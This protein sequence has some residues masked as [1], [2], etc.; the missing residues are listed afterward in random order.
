[1]TTKYPL[2]VRLDEALRKAARLLE[3][4]ADTE[5]RQIVWRDNNWLRRDLIRVQTQIARV[6]S[7]GGETIEQLRREAALLA[8]DLTQAIDDLDLAL[9]DGN[10]A[11]T[12]AWEELER[13][14]AVFT[15]RAARIRDGEDP[16]GDD[17]T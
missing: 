4:A 13:L 7:G 15:V 1:M 6:P 14:V 9:D 17:G 5:P 12:G 2:A 16:D 11:T 8:R 3:E 10:D